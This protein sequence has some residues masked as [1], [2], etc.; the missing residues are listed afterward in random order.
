MMLC[1]GEQILDL[2]RVA[3]TSQAFSR[4]ISGRNNLDSVHKKSVDHLYEV[5]LEVC[6]SKGDFLMWRAVGGETQ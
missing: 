2:D 6:C 5:T 3:N 1:I 4:Q